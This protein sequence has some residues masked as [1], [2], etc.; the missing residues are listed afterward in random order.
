MSSFPIL[1]KF[2]SGKTVTLEV[3]SDTTIAVLKEKLQDKE[4]I[5]CSLQ[6]FYACGHILEDHQTL[7]ELHIHKE[8]V[9]HFIDSP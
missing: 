1:I 5:P 9:I 3:E 7:E 8:A 6:T 2:K 4:G